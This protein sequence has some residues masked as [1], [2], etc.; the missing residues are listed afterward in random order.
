MKAVEQYLSLYAEPESRSVELGSRFDRVVA[1]PSLGEEL[2]PVISSL[3]KAAEHSSVKVLLVIVVNSRPDHSEELR[4]TNRRFLD[5]VAP[6]ADAIGDKVYFCKPDRLVI[7]RCDT[8]PPKQGVGLARKIGGDVCL[9]L[10]TT[11]SV[12]SKWI[13]CTDG[14]CEVPRDYFDIAPPDRTAACL[15]PFEHVLDWSRP[16]E[17]QAL[18][19]YDESLRYY[20]DGLKRAG[21][22]YAY[23]SLGSTLAIHSD[24]YAMARGFP[25][26]AAAED[27]YLLN[28]LAK[29]GRIVSLEGPT[30]RIY[31]RI[32]DR[33][34]FGTG[35]STRK[36]SEALAVGLRIPTYNPEIFSHLG[37]F[38]SAA[39]TAL[40]N[41]RVPLQVESPPPGLGDAIE[42]AIKT[43][44][45]TEQRLR[46][47]NDWFDAFRTLKYVH[48]L[49]DEHYGTV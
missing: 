23:Q 34:P 29:L 20:V 16:H 13:H 10:I 1:I 27:F 7:D 35:V 36:F 25:K 37:G 8:F 39:R 18:K 47:F 42:T 46:H 24:C 41:P 45:S 6:E 22:P 4:Q 2:G 28:K 14:D 32:S 33:V 21:S 38:L 17:A 9:R 11:G 15:Y 48:Q 26:T 31:Q 40:E 44:T 5:S 43:R 19:L 30:L 12:V 3:R 49:R